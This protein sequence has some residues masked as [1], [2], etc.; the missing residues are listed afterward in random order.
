MKYVDRKGNISEIDSKQDKFLKELYSHIS[1]RILLKILIHPTISKIGGWILN[2]RI[3]SLF[4][5]SFIKHNQ[6]DLSQY[7]LQFFRSYNAFF[8]R[9]IKKNYR[10]ISKAENV[11]ISPCDGKLSVY[12][13]DKKQQ[14]Q[15][16]NTS[17]T[18]QSLLH[19]QR[20]AQ[21]FNGGYACIFRLTVDD[22][23]RFCYID[24]GEKS[25][26][27]LIKG[28]FHTVNPI[29]NDIF[30]IYKENTREF[31][32]LKSKHFGKILAMEVGALLVGKINN[33]HGKATV[34]KGQEKGYFEF[35]GSTIVL[36]FQKDKVIIDNDLLENTKNGYETI[37]KMGEKI[38]IS[39]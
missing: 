29:A 25:D 35:G 18:I 21:Y 26:N 10:P 22:Y 30:P 33:Y 38:G 11:L 34:K 39:K 36:L 12:K 24:A 20:L 13:I 32:L 6:I 37:V 28:V 1:G 2:T 9:Q 19:S 14:F 15:I 7:Q 5:N 16:K 31:C 17:Y 8:T 3:S 4:I 27:Y 23:H